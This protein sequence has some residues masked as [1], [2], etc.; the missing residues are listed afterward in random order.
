LMADLLHLT[1]AEKA[2]IAHGL[3]TRYG[4]DEP[5]SARKRALKK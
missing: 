2:L 1:S 4:A 5:N 3:P